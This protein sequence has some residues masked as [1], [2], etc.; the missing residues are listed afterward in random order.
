[1]IKIFGSDL[2]EIERIGE[3]VESAVRTVPA[4]RSAFAER[5]AGGYII[6]FDLKRDQL[7]RYCLTV[8][9]A[10]DV[11]M[12][13]IGGEPIT[14]VIKGR[15][16]YSVSLRYPRELRED[17]SLLERVLVPT[18]TGAQVPLGQIASIRLV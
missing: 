4:T 8:D 1:M 14:T 13:A 5:V 16:R 7:A 6:D 9:D 17:V 10:N 18:M 11:I 3:D 2:N 12:T 15:E